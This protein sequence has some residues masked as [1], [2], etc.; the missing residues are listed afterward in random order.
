[1]I[2]THECQCGRGVQLVGSL[3][4]H[5]P[6]HCARYQAAIDDK[7][8]GAYIEQLAAVELTS[9]AKASQ[10]RLCKIAYQ[11]RAGMIGALQ[12][13]AC[14]WPIK[15][16]DTST[17]HDELCPTHEIMLSQ[18]DVKVREVGDV[19]EQMK[20]LSGHHCPLNCACRFVDVALQGGV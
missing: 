14:A 13:C 18:C 1:V 15:R 20:Q 2:A 17:E 12:S 16:Y 8:F 11:Q 10:N 3:V 9:T 7:S 6:P 4:R 5:A 19:G